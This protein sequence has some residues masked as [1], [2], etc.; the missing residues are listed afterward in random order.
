MG[1]AGVG[2]DL[3]DAFSEA[4]VATVEAIAPSVA[5]VAVTGDGG[6]PAGSG[7]GFFLTPDGFLL[8]NA[9]V[10]ASGKG[11]A[12]TL[13]DGSEHPSSVVGADPRTD[14]AVLHVEAP[15]QAAAR[16]GDSDALR[17][18]QLV[19]AFGSPLGLDNT[20]SVGIVASLGRS[21]RAPS[22]YLVERVI[23]SDTALNPGNSGGPLADTR[24]RV[25]G[26]NSAMIERA[27]GLGFAV[28]IN[29][30]AFVFGEIL[31]H[32]RVRRY[33]LG[34]KGK[35]R[36]IPRKIQHGLRLDRPSLIEIVEVT[37]DGPAARA[38]FRT[39]DLFYSL[40]DE[41]VASMDDLNRILSRSGGKEEF[42][43]KV[44]R[45]GNAETFRL[46]PGKD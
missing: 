22:G 31:A 36:P 25:V 3:L 26:V 20:V 9:H 34:I 1:D 12:V 24:G 44:L 14:L 32:G 45:G 10:I 18:G 41:Q 40:N 23:Q 37:A 21:L 28:P 7:S 19:V 16:L 17:V 29:T 38:G 11:F 35:Y 39:G 27:Q 46:K 15:P 33:F 30:A 13:A 2:G 43:A 6:K 8:T 5:A 4:V 42:E